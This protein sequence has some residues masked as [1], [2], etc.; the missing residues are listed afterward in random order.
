MYKQ[1]NNSRLEQS[2]RP[3]F[4]WIKRKFIII[5]TAFMLG[6]ANGM[7]TEDTR[8]K[9]NQNYTEQHKKD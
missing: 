2:K 4:H 1:N 6:M 5:I 9:G 7:H 3:L 8:I